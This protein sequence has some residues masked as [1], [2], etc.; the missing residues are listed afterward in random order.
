MLITL[1]VAVEHGKNG[2]VDIGDEFYIEQTW[3]SNWRLCFGPWE[4]DNHP[5]AVCDNVADCILEADRIKREEE[6]YLKKKTWP[7]EWHVHEDSLCN[8]FYTTQ[9]DALGFKTRADGTLHQVI[10]DDAIC[11]TMGKWPGRYWR[12]AEEAQRDVQR[13][14]DDKMR[15]KLGGSK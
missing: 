7:L 6:W 10:R 9:S 11:W 3:T 13:E 15:A 4:S 14:H 5:L 2:P 1:D 8:D 12:N